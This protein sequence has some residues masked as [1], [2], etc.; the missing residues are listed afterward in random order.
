MSETIDIVYSPQYSDQ[1]STSSV[2]SIIPEHL[3][4]P[5]LL[6]GLPSA[7]P[8]YDQLMVLSALCKYIPMD[9]PAESLKIN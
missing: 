9:L 5:Q 1:E 6:Q 4:F 7:R 2:L 3:D 8:Q